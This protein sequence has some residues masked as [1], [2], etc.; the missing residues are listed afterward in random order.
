VAF[1]IDHLRAAGGVHVTG[2]G[3]D[4]A[5]T[6]VDFFAPGII[7]CSSPG[8]LGR[9]ASRYQSD[10]SRPSRRPGSQRAFQA[11]L[12]YESSLWKHFHALRPLKIALGCPS[13][14]VRDLF[15]RTFRKNACRLHLVQTA[16]RVRTALDASDADVERVSREVRAAG[17][18]FGV[19]VEEDGE[20]C[21]FLDERG[22]FIS[23]RLI[24]T[25]LI[26]ERHASG[27]GRPDDFFQ[28]SSSRRPTREEVTL[29]MQRD[30]LEFAQ[31]GAGRYWFADPYPACDALL[32]LVHLMRIL[33]RSDAP[34]SE[35]AAA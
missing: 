12:P 30:G 26:Q 21:V 20:T 10:Y 28:E 22:H 5:W 34:F 16:I 9:I 4:P 32:T 11:A 15:T 19:F 18:H 23:P 14:A 35:I 7:P 17:A 25:L 2:A 3:C 24:G 13:R 33:S 1:A 29:A 6:G 31:D 8:G 27:A